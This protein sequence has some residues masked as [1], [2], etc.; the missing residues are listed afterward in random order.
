MT[1][2]FKKE[3]RFGNVR[4]MSQRGTS[5]QASHKAR[6]AG[7]LHFL[8]SVVFIIFGIIAIRLFD[9]QILKHTYYTALAESQRLS[10]QDLI[11]ERGKIFVKEGD[12]L[13][14]LVTNKSTKMLYTS[15]RELEGDKEE[16]AEKLASILYDF[17]RRQEER[18]EKSLLETA[19]L[20][21]K[22]EETEKKGDEEEL[23]PE[24]KEKKEKREKEKIKNE[25]LTRILKENDP[26]EPL[27]HRLDD[28][29][30]SQIEEL[31]I[32]GL[33]LDDEPGRFYPEGTLAA[34]ILGFVGF[35]DSA[36][37]GQYGIEEYFDEILRGKIGAL[38]VEK[39]TLGHWIS[40]GL[41]EM[42][43]A[44]NGADIILT[45]DRTVQ[46]LVESKL[47][48]A[49][50]KYGAHS[51]T[52]I[53]I[54]PK[55]G[56]VL[57]LANYPTFDPNIYQASQDIGS[58]RNQAISDLFEPGSV[59]KPVVMAMA[60]NEGKVMPDTSII[61]NGPVHIAGYTIDTFDGK[62]HGRETMTEILENSCNVGMVKVSQ[63]LGR[64]TMYDYL[65]RF[66]IGELSGLSLAGEEAGYLEEPEKW[67]IVKEAT[68]SFGQGVVMTPIQLITAISAIA[69]NG[70]LM[71]PMIIDSII[72]EDGSQKKY[73]PKEV[74]RVIS[75]S[76]AATLSAMLV[77]AVENGVGKPAEVPG[78]HIAGKTGTAQVAKPEG[79]Y[80]EASERRVT[81]FVGYGP[82]ENPRF[83][84]LVVF[85]DPERA[86]WGAT[87]AAPVFKEIASELFNYYKIAPSE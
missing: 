51:G 87:S 13:F 2:H 42:R 69:N 49:V 27:A 25:I 30:A 50:L 18:V 83:V 73:D 53:V 60:L 75:P 9:I 5:G 52:I 28:E 35:Q 45:I 55:T 19:K 10:Y 40:I 3:G 41:K 11:P 71:Q 86:M 17:E 46:H 84:V 34:H 20:N 54:E 33:F 63:M 74:R 4:H 85:K 16:I 8:I 48:E 77:S 24:E 7:R 68:V 43:P 29:A 80:W 39:D 12:R 67:D 62:H 21:I 56:K 79:G 59:F 37:V 76:K 47:R 32:E 66:G 14:P 38:G 61:D 1:R 15:P 6:R 78:F 65:R 23:S 64:E 82:V 44:K 31:N 22:E 36:R 72:R 58:F 26:Y 70:V 57:A 81:S